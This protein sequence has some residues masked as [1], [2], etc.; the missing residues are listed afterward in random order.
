M[1]I[2]VPWALGLGGLAVSAVVRA[3]MRSID[4]RVLYYDAAVDPVFP[5][6]R[7]QKVFL[8]WHEYLLVPM[9]F[10]GRCNL[11]SL[12]SRHRDAEILWH[13]TRHF[14]C[15]VVRG[16][17]GRG[18][19]AAVRTLMRRSRAMN[20]GIIPDGPRGPRRRMAPGAIQLA[21]LLGLPIVV[22]GI[23]YD[24]PW[25]IRSAW[26]QTAIP[27][28]FSRARVIFS[29]EVAVPPGL[30][31][32]GLEHF[33]RHVEALLNRLTEEAES[34]AASGRGRPGQMAF[35]PG[36]MQTLPRWLDPAH[37][38]AMPQPAARLPLPG[39]FLRDDSRLAV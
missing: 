24:R 32:T 39:G 16:S 26:D 13:V 20:L 12:L 22:L 31:D 15:H 6:W 2:D 19:V 28:P 37:R 5:E 30:D 38:A 36:R 11:A 1:K 14:G 7:G 10:R 21:S 35:V 25:R 4:T 33:R 17:T 8:C 9:Y 34:W 3:W 29:P 18:G 27:R 23:G